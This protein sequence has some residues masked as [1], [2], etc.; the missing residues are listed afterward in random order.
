MTGWLGIRIMCPSGTKCL[1]TESC[2]SELAILKSSL[3]CWSSTKQTSSSSHWKLTCSCH[4]MA[5][6]IA[7]VALNYNHPLTHYKTNSFYTMYN[8]KS[9]KLYWPNMFLNINQ[10]F[11]G[12]VITHLPVIY[13]WYWIGKNCS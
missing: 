1:P 6:K 13:N 10:T 11:P 9:D 7:Y 3:G 5:E 12:N 2:F 4:D 8:A